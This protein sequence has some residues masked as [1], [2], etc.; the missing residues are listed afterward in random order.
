[1]Y[2]FLVTFITLWTLDSKS[3]PKLIGP[4][5]DAIATGVGRRKI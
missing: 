1:M 5:K 2:N 4:R 3:M